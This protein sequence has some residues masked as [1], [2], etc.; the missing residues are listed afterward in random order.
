MM[1]ELKSCFKLLKYSHQA[2]LNIVLGIAFFL[3]GIVENIA[4]SN[5]G[6]E[7][8]F[9]VMMP[10]FLCQM[11]YCLVYMGMVSTSARKRVLAVVLP[12]VV[13]AAGVAFGIIVWFVCWAVREKVMKNSN[14]FFIRMETEHGLGTSLLL[15]G[16]VCCLLMLYMAACYKYYVA[17]TICFALGM[18]VFGGASVF[19]SDKVKLTNIQGALVLFLLYVLG[20]VLSGALRRLLYRRPISKLAVGKIANDIK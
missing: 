14:L 1:N 6:F 7:I 13:C 16:V 11:S 15:I 2:A 9:L 12:D 4:M 17:S 18:S 20:V 8:I 5:M 3:F 10:I 19:I